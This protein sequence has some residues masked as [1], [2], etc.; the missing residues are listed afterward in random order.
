MRLVA[1]VARYH[2][3]A[4]PQPHHPAFTELDASDQ[5][6]VLRLG[7]ML[8]VADSLD[9]EHLQRVEIVQARIG[10][11]EVTIH[12]EGSVGVLLEDWAYK[13]KSQ[14]F[15]EIFDK[16][17]RLHFIDEGERREAVS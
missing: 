7:A 2:R 5:D 13:K 3:K 17:L 16:K 14:L 6:R 4:H 8:R 12:L 10:K 9:R 15:A 1:N 11:D